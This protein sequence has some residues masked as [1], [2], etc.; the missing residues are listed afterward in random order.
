MPNSIT[1]KPRNLI[2][3]HMIGLICGSLF[4]LI[5]HA[6]FIVFNIVYALA[7]GSTFFLMVTTDTE[8]PP[9][10]GT[11]L[12]IALAGFSF[13]LA[14]ALITSVAILASIHYFFKPYLKDL[15]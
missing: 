15:V 3:G 12:G 13:D 2:G 6:S 8:H 14:L 4:A 7:V 11:A 9:A 5:P 10:A 1:A